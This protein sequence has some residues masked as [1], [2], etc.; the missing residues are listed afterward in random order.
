M[1]VGK[2]VG[3]FVTVAAILARA[4]AYGVR[5]ALTKRAVERLEKRYHDRADS[6]RYLSEAMGK[7]KV[8]EPTTTAY[9][10]VSTLSE[11]MAANV[12]GIVGRADSLQANAQGLSEA[13]EAEHGRMRDAN[14]THTVQ[15]A[16]AKFI[17][18]R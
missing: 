9:M 7:L 4:T 10:E 18:P 3:S 6:A 1:S 13:T 16:Q 17:Q 14:R 11:A 5:A 15:M 2:A 8:D 12:A